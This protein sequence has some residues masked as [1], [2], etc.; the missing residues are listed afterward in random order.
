MLRKIA[1][2]TEQILGGIRPV[3]EKAGYETTGTQNLFLL[4]G[5]YISTGLGFLGLGAFL[6]IIYAG[7]LWTT[8]QGNEDQV[9]KAQT[10]IKNAVIGLGIITM[11]FAI[12][13]FLFSA[14]AI[15][16]D[17]EFAASPTRVDSRQALQQQLAGRDLPWYSQVGE[18]FMGVNDAD[19]NA[20]VSRLGDADAAAYLNSDVA[21][22]NFGNMV[23]RAAARAAQ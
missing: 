18:F 9:E 23:Q 11:A 15:A 16:S 13:N 14:A 8:A 4:I 5:R 21:R 22:I 6:I 12:A 2:T 17:S 1:V 3:A 20:A 10:Y 7:Y 19:Y